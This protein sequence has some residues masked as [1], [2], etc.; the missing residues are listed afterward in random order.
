M[1]IAYRLPD[2]PP[3]PAI[4][5][6][7]GGEPPVAILPSVVTWWCFRWVCGQ[8]RTGRGCRRSAERF[9]PSHAF[10][11]WS[12][13]RKQGSVRMVV[14]NT[15]SEETEPARLKGIMRK[16]RMVLEMSET[17]LVARRGGSCCG[18]QS[19]FASVMIRLGCFFQP[20]TNLCSSH[21]RAVNI[22]T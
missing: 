14:Q 22:L 1:E 2:E 6:G 18:V 11:I 19:S 17:E 9:G 8:M 5:H 3:A 15:A 10:R 20:R 13:S 7:F 16:S 12:D 21:L 4:S